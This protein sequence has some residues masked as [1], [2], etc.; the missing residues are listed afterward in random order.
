MSIKVMS[1]VW[2]HSTHKGSDLLLLLAIADHA[3]DHGVAYPSIARLMQKIRMSER[4]VQYGLRHLQKSG[5]LAVVTGAGPGGTHLY[6]IK[7]PGG[8]G[9]KFAPHDVFENDK[10]MTSELPDEKF[11][12]INGKEQGNSNTSGRGGAK[13]AGGKG[14]GVQTLHPIFVENK[15]VTKRGGAKFAPGGVQPIAP[16]PSLKERSGKKEYPP[17]SA[18]VPS[19]EP[20][21][22]LSDAPKAPQ[23]THAS[24]PQGDGVC[25]QRLRLFFPDDQEG[26]NK[27]RAEVLTDDM[28]AWAKGMTDDVGFEFD[29]WLDDGLDKNRR[30]SNFRSAFRKW[31]TSPYQQAAADFQARRPQSEAEH[32]REMDAW[33]REEEQSA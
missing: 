3:D 19:A 31:L 24:S 8:G 2:E 18:R 21:P 15:G 1:Y 23:T 33:I 27:L 9:A 12:P 16:K 29:R 26:Q 5:E 7:L 17:P 4:N 6:Q 10:S 20:F 30:S 22:H 14:K 13:F 25:V 28:M 11:A 32:R